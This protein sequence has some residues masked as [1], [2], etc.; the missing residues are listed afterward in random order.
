MIVVI[1]A[2]MAS[3]GILM[4]LALLAV[5]AKDPPSS[6][7]SPH[8]KSC[9]Y[10]KPQGTLVTVPPP[11]SADSPLLPQGPVLPLDG[12][13]A[14]QVPPI[15]GPQAITFYGPVAGEAQRYVE[16][17]NARSGFTDEAHRDRYGWWGR[18]GL[19][20]PSAP[21]DQQQHRQ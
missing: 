17:V 14:Q 2:I 9:P 20:A 12:D 13:D 19:G 18:F 11:V 1:V 8:G 16:A 21:A 15:T 5:S 3:A 4:V 7:R 6:V 10:C